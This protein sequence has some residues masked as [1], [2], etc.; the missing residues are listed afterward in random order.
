MAFITCGPRFDLT[1]GHGHP[2][3][4]CMVSAFSVVAYLLVHNVAR[5]LLGQDQNYPA[6]NFNSKDAN[7]KDNQHVDVQGDHARWVLD[8]WKSWNRV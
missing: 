1:T 3:S 2:Y 5:Y 8:Y 7:S 4:C 6:V